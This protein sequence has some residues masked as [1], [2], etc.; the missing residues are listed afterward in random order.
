[1]LLLFFFVGTTTLSYL[2][3]NNIN[4]IFFFLLFGPVFLLGIKRT[5][6]PCDPQAINTRD[7]R[8]VVH[9]PAQRKAPPALP[10]SNSPPQHTHTHTPTQPSVTVIPLLLSHGPAS[11]E[12]PV[13]LALLLV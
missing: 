2:V 13:N 9:T 7:I 6:K 5:S 8:C 3:L 1:M 12:K 4:E 11:A 10:A